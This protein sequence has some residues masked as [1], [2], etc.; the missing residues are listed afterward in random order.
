MRLIRAAAAE[1]I[2]LFV[3]DWAQSIGVLVIL[4]AG[5]LASHLL[6]TSISGFGVALLL[7]AHLMYS[8]SAEGE[9]R[10]GEQTSSPGGDI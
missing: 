7:A 10:S 9:H 4:G 5:Y 8:A 6:P 3:A 1:F 2:G